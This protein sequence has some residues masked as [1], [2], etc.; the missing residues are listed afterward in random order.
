MAMERR[1]TEVNGTPYQM[2]VPPVR[3]AMQLCTRTAVLLGSVLG[4]LKLDAAEKGME[5]F[6]AALKNVDPDKADA[7]LMDAVK[8]AHVCCREAPV[9]DPVSFEKHFTT[10]RADV[11]PVSLWALWECVREFFPQLGAL[12][13]LG[14]PRAGGPAGAASASPTGGAKTGGSGGPSGKGFAVTTNLGTD[15]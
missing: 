8:V 14:T 12:S 9:S 4:T 7:L 2:L 5:A 11:Y 13:P 10:H 3:Q 6:A 15:R 1:D